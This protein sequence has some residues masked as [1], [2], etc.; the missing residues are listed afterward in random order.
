MELPLEELHQIPEEV[1]ALPMSTA[2]CSLEGCE[3]LWEGKMLE[4]WT[5]L[6]EGRSLRIIKIVDPEKNLVELSF[7]EDGCTVMDCLWFLEHLPGP[8][9]ALVKFK[10]D[11]EL[12]TVGLG[13]QDQEQ[14]SPASLLLMFPD[15]PQ[16][17][18]ILGTLAD[19]E[20]RTATACSPAGW[21]E[22]GS[23]VLAPWEGGCFR[24]RVLAVEGTMLS[25]L[26]V[27]YGNCST[28]DW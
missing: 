21:V 4:D 24:A 19:L 23:A 11:Q 26:F 16:L 1:A 18:E 28:V 25:V 3:Q 15:K 12:G 6:V 13:S 8:K 27:D 7:E 22:E 2:Q 9:G 5:R 14:P 10:Q 20:E 17:V